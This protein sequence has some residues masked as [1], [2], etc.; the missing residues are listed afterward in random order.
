MQQ[1]E[2]TQPRDE[3]HGHAPND[4][5]EQACSSAAA[6]STGSRRGGLLSLPKILTVAADAVTIAIAMAVAFAL[7]SL[8]PGSNSAHAHDHL[9][10]GALSVPLWIAVFA[11]CHL[12]TAR[13]ITRRLQELG[14]VVRALFVSVCTAAGLSFLLQL[15]ISRGWLVLCFFV[16]LVAVQCER[17][18]VRRIFKGLRAKGRMLRPIVVVGTNVEALGLCA[19]L[20]S[21]PWLGYRVMGMVGERNPDPPLLEG[22]PWLGTI[23]ELPNAL[24]RTGSGGVLIAT[25]AVDCETSNRLT[26]QLTDASIHVELSSSLRDIRAERLT[27]RSLGGFPV[28]YVEPVQRRGW[29]AAGKRTFDIVAAGSGL[30]ILAPA[31]LVI[32]ALVKLDSPGP[33]L[34]RQ[35]RVGK[36]GRTFKVLKF[37]TMVPDAERLLADLYEL[38]EADGP[39]FKIRRD[40]RVTRL[41]RALRALSLDELPQLYNVLRDEMS[42]VGPRPALPSETRSW[43]PQL[44]QRLRVKPGLTGMWQVNG[45]SDVSF[46]QYAR[47][48]L[49]YVDN[50]SLWMDL[51]IVAKTIPTLLLRRGGY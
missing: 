50:W 23:D 10:A 42:I 18:L 41:G 49:Y 35:E 15:Q 5:A 39:L 46:D 16:A 1:R 29:R 31:L 43:S 45:R 8:I 48:D 20:Q 30:V 26:R 47:L 51:A 14:L 24:E 6:F 25:T 13:R 9:V 38:N 2:F 4:T 21:E 19:T 28:V 36:D 32:A 44:H 27:V 22:V 3:T 37:R 7:R 40:P 34:F 11:R 12:Y 33:A 17:E